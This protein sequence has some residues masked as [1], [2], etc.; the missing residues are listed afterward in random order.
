[1]PPVSVECRAE[2]LF[3]DRRFSRQPV[4]VRG[5]WF[6][7]WWYVTCSEPGGDGRAVTFK[8]LPASAG[9]SRRALG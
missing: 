9:D 2:T 7:V 3:Q 8:N 6:R 5:V 1:M 4:V